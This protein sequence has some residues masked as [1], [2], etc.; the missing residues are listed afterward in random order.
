MTECKTSSV[1]IAGRTIGVGAPCFIIAEAGVNHNGHV[2]LAHKLIDAARDAGAD[3]VKFQT[4]SADA[5]ATAS[6]EKAAYQKT[7]T[8]AGS[9]RDM[10]RAL[11]LRAEDFKALKNH[12]RQAE[13]LFLSSPFDE[14]GIDLLDR[15]DVSAFKIPSGDLTNTPYLKHMARKRRPVILSTGM[16][17]IDEVGQAINTLDRDGAKDIVLLHCVSAYPA[18][19]SDLNLRAMATLADAFGRPVGLSDHSLGTSVAIAAVALSACVIEKHLTLD[20]NMPGP[21]HS[22]SLEPAVFGQ[23]VQAIRQVEAALGDGRKEPCAAERDTARVARKSLHAR[24]DLAAGAILTADSIIIA[25]PETG[26]PP[27]MFESVVGRKLRNTVAAGDPIR[28]DDLG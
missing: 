21:D 12:C 28:Q 2:D 24:H 23:M 27:A 20:R 26:L 9:Q 11:E 6:A 16:A 15:L 8:G 18:D 25:R 13:L 19:Y 5:L 17:T 14:V 4:F 7:S 1:V 10:L 3:A 22:A